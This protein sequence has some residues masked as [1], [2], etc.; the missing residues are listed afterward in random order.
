M[1]GSLTKA[2]AFFNEIFELLIQRPELISDPDTKISDL[3]NYTWIFYCY[4]RGNFSVCHRTCH[5]IKVEILL[6]DQW[7]SVHD[8]VLLSYCVTFVGSLVSP[9]Y[10]RKMSDSK[11]FVKFWVNLIA[12]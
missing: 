7:E 8:L 5:L 2:H 9:A 11:L 10:R 4:C 6:K 1:H 3:K 12:V